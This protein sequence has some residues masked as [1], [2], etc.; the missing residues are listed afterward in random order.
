MPLF[1]REIP[2]MAHEPKA[3]NAW[4]PELFYDDSR[5]R[6]LIFWASTIPGRFPETDHTG[7]NETNHRIYYVTTRDFK[8]F[9]LARLFFDPGFNVIDATIVRDGKGYVL[10]FKDERQTPVK[11]N[12][13]LARAASAEGPYKDVTEAFTRD[14]VEGPS[15]LRVGKE[16]VVYFDQYRE[17]KYG[18]VKSTNFRDWQD[19]TGELTFPADYRHGSVLRISPATAR[20]LISSDG[21]GR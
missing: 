9:S 21:N 10:I 3:R 5:R 15:V 6:W 2:V 7:N 16:W 12:I 13:R 11:K 20:R 14:W 4:A 1:R 8:T 18:A 19:I 17:R